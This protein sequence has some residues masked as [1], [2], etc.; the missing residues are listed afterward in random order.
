MSN[1][2]KTKL[3]GVAEGANNYTLPS[4][5]TALGGVIT[6]NDDSHTHTW[7]RTTSIQLS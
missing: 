5:G 6:V 2:D 4:A 3:D 7:L 1:T